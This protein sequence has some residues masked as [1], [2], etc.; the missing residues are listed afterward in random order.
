MTG[1]QSCTCNPINLTSWSFC[2]IATKPAIVPTAQAEE[3]EI[4]VMSSA[5]E[6]EMA[7]MAAEIDNW[8]ESRSR[9]KLQAGRCCARRLPHLEDAVADSI[10]PI[11]HAPAS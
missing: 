2:R 3:E 4:E 11:T 10:M 1:A 6:G 8:R 7:G 5:S 9:M